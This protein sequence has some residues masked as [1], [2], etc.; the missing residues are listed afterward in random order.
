MEPESTIMK[1]VIVK[2]VETQEEN[3]MVADQ[4]FYAFAASPGSQENQLKRREYYKSAREF[5]V[6]DDDKPA[7][8]A[9]YVPMTQNIRGKIYEMGGVAGVAT[10]PE[11]RRKGYV[12]LLMRKLFESMREEKRAISILYPFRESFYAKFGYITSLQEYD[13]NF[14]P[15]NLRE[16]PEIKNNLRMERVEFNKGLD[17][18]YNLHLESQKLFHGFSMYEKLWMKAAE[19]NPP[20]LILLRDGDRVVG[21]MS[22]KITGFSGTMKIGGLL[23]LT[24]RAKYSLFH[25]IARHAD[26]VTKVELPLNPMFKL[27]TWIDDLKITKVTREWVPSHMFRVISIDGLSGMQIGDGKINLKIT[28]SHCDWNNG[29]WEFRSKNKK[30]EVRRTS[31]EPDAELTIDGLSAIIYGVYELDDFEI[32]NWGRL[33]EATKQIVRSLFPQ[34][35]PYVSKFV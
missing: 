11:A 21:G 27:E 30:L 6:L 29:N 3:R 8:T 16:L 33:N 23:Y 26:H 10:Y 18:Y 20:W 5:I 22:Y 24:P 7:S 17:D 13:G 9:N 35:L 34:K 28:D 1:N 2:K 14:S 25:W 19:L 4:M 31:D 12:K 15:S 32:K